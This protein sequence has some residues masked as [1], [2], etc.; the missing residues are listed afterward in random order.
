MT[1]TVSVSGSRG[2]GARVAPVRVRAMG[3][4]DIPA[5]LR[6]CRAS[7]WNQIA[8]DWEL[9][10]AMSPDGCRVAID[11]HGAVIGSV[12]T[13]RYGEALSWVAMVL[14]DPARRGEGIGTRLLEEALRLLDGVPTVRL[15]AT[16]AGHGVYLPLGFCEEYRLQ[17]LERPAS[18]AVPGEASAGDDGSSPVVRPMTDADLAEVFA[19]DLAAFGADRSELLRAFQCGAPDYAWVAGRH[20]IEGFL[21]GRHGH[22]F[23]HLGPLV[24]RDE[25]LARRLVDA[26]LAAHAGRPFILDAPPHRAWMEWLA[27]RQFTAQRPF[28]RMYRGPRRHEE[29][30]GGIFASA[31]AEFS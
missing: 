25:S 8:R 12:A 26:C 28:V 29:T 14:V 1:E 24:A 6:L 15:D 31:G 11:D 20:A 21:L 27:A 2:R 7:H 18:A 13:L 5:G 19:L 22:T 10:L 17:R 4:G 30:L 23:E 3:R 9:F 16:P